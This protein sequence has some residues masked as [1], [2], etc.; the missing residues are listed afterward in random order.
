MILMTH[1]LHYITLCTGSCDPHDSLFTLHGAL[2]SL[3]I[4]TMQIKSV[5]LNFLVCDR[6]AKTVCC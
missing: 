6:S 3:L 4:S 1:G 5:L 2:S